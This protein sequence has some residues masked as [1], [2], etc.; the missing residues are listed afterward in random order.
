MLVEKKS[1]AYTKHLCVLCEVNRGWNSRHVK[2]I[3][4]RPVLEKTQKEVSE[5]MV[6]L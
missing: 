6:S 3:I 4:Y 2:V 5:M 1:M